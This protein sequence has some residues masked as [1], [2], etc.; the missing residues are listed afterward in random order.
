MYK[1]IYIF[2]AAAVITAC[3][4][5]IKED[6]ADVLL[7][8][9]L[10]K[11]MAG[12]WETLRFEV[13]V[14]SWKG[15]DKDTIIVVENSD[16]GRLVPFKRNTGEYKLDGTFEEFFYKT[17]DSLMIK[18]SGSWVAEGDTIYVQ[19]LYPTFT[20]NKYIMELKNDTG[21][22]TSILDWDRDSVAD[23]RYIGTSIKLSAE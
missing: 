23:D 20:E 19:Q 14:S 13:H 22:F 2:F 16:F 17:N 9:D 6:P 15:T 3:N 5:P 8:R 1:L 21:T 7:E 4:N 11:D 12:K 10:A 18:V